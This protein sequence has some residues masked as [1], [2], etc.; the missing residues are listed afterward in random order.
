MMPRELTER[1]QKGSRVTLQVTT[2]LHRLDKDGCEA[3]GML[4]D[5]PK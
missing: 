4:S 1:V 2:S 3:V 5:V